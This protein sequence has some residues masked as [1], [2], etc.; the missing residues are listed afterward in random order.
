M[1]MFLNAILNKDSVNKLTNPF[2][3]NSLR[4]EVSGVHLNFLSKLPLIVNAPRISCLNLSSLFALFVFLL[5]KMT[6]GAF[7]ID[8][9]LPTL[10]I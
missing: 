5:H 1:C 3:L 4:C 8:S 6:S 2:V 9:S 10:D 7:T